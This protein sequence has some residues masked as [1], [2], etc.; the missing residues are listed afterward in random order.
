[1]ANRVVILKNLCEQ[2]SDTH[3]KNLIIGIEKENSI[4]CNSRIYIIY[5][6]FILCYFETLLCSRS[7][8]DK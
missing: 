4:R 5:L 7:T 1:M 2:V 3:T 8:L 6:G